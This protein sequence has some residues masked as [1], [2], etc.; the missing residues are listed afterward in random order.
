MTSSRTTRAAAVGLALGFAAAGVGCSSTSTDTTGSTGTSAMSA[1]TTG[2]TAGTAAGTTP[3][4]AVAMA[5]TATPAAELR[6]TMTDLLVSHVYLAGIALQTAVQ[7]GPTSPQTAAATEAL[8]QNSMQ[9]ADAV[10]SVYGPEAGDQFLELWRKHIGFF[11]D[12]TVAKASGDDEAANIAKTALDGYLLDL[13]AFLAAAN[14]NLTEDGVAEALVPHVDTLFAAIDLMV[15]K[16]P[17]APSALR[18]AAAA[19]PPIAAVL[20]DAIVT[21][22][23]LEGAADGD[24]AGLRAGL[25]TLLDEHVYLA[26]IL[27]VTALATSP[28]SPEATAAAAALD[29]NSVAFADAVGTIYG[30]E[31]GDQFLELWR[32]H[33]GFFVDYTVARATGDDEAANIAKTG[34]N[35]YFLDLGAFLAA[36]NPNLTE[37]GVAE[38]L[39]P[40][41]ETLFSTID[42]AAAGD[43]GTYDAL[44]QAAG[45]MP[46]IAAA[47][48]GAIATQQDMQ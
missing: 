41:A 40:H 14:P 22:Q 11:V 29:E 31:A 24:A 32:K 13:G 36:A 6:A 2:R 20:T 15:A 21:Q 10:G 3:G 35:G 7:T 23:E 27:V 43:A 4:S 12:Y 30:P 44:R 37:D 39:V 28:D 8:D 45:A 1:D 18:Q 33:I 46:P 5:A 17:T 42:L 34:L 26:G 25:T 16:D 9:I 47:L 19:M 38:A 48:A